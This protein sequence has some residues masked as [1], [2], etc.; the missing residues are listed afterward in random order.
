MVIV[1]SGISYFNTNIVR[2]ELEDLVTDAKSGLYFNTNIV[3]L[4]L[5]K[6]FK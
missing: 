2:L 1:P 5:L 3:R 4:E 6:F